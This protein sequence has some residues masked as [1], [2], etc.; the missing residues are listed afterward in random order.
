MILKMAV[1]FLHQLL[2]KQRLLTPAMLGMRYLELYN[3]HVM[4]MGRG[5]GYH[6]SADVRSCCNVLSPNQN[7]P[8]LY[9]LLYV[10]IVQ[11]PE[12][13]PLTNGQVIV[14]SRTVGSVAIYICLSGYT[15]QGE[16]ER[17]CQSDGTWSGI[18]PTC[19]L[20]MFPFEMTL[21]PRVENGQ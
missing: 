9:Y 17:T 19:I 14:P 13:P 5:Q 15:T 16:D 8:P 6:Q 18:P 11:C 3:E 7:F 2:S 10:A 1:L 4:L 21:S 12:L 20:S